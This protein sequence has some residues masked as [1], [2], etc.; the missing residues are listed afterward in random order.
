VKEAG[1]A[2]VPLSSFTTDPHPPRMVRFAFCKTDE[3]LKEAARRLQAF[4]DR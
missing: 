1:V 4:A 3:M 2:T